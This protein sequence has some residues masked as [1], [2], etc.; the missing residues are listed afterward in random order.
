MRYAASVK[1]LPEAAAIVDP[2]VSDIIPSEAHAEV[3]T[4]MQRIITEQGKDP[5]TIYLRVERLDPDT[6]NAVEVEVREPFEPYAARL[7]GLWI[8]NSLAGLDRVR[9]VVKAPYLFP[10]E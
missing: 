6:T 7:T 5:T 1:D 9:V 4:R 3:V 10:S 2:E 8:M